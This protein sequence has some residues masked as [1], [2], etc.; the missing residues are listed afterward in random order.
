LL[1]RWDHGG[2]LMRYGILLA[3]TLLLIGA[4]MFCGFRIKESRSARTFLMLTLAI[5]PVNAAVLGGLV[6]SQF[7]LDSTRIL[8]PEFVWVAPSPA[9]A[10][11]CAAITLTVL[12]PVSWFAFRTLAKPQA[13]PLTGAFILSNALL[14][15]PFRVPTLTSLVVLGT[16][17]LVALADARKFSR[18]SAMR[19]LEGRVSRMMLLV[20]VFLMVARGIHLYPALFLHWGSLL[21]VAGLLFLAA[22]KRPAANQWRDGLNT[23]AAMLLGGGY[24]CWWLYW[25]EQR[26]LG[27]ALTLPSLLLPLAVTLAI[28]S[29]RLG[30]FRAMARGL[31]AVFALAAVVPNLWCFPDTVTL[32]ACAALGAL[33]LAYGVSVRSKLLCAGGGIAVISAIIYQLIGA[34]K[35]DMLTHW[36]TLS[37]LGVVLIIIAAYWER[38][39]LDVIR[40]VKRWRASAEQWQY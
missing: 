32:L 34:V 20:P 16:A 38:Y 9:W 23:G 15:L 19:T 28:L 24:S 5:V 30:P 21:L 8:P 27:G 22:A 7:A 26:W 3:H 11:I 39:H 35:L 13:T 10:L 33:V 36:A 4:A 12:G 14:V 6:Y 2:D 17:S 29:T 18:G 25:C 31:A 40:T 37:S 1:H